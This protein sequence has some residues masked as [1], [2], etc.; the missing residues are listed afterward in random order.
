VAAIFQGKSVIPIAATMRVGLIQV[1]GPMSKILAI[2]LIVIAASPTQ[3]K[4]APLIADSELALGG[5]ALGDSEQA[6][7][8]KLGKPANVTDTGD[9]LN[10]RLDYPGLTI[11]L[12]EGRRVGE[13]LSTASGQCSPS[14][15][16]PGQRLSVATAQLGPGLVADREDGRFMEYPSAQSS[17][18]LQLAVLQG[19][20]VSVRAECQP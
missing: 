8:A 15:I 14:G 11:W 3:A 19:I 12:G 17:C 6:V 18:W 4:Q 1:L 10:I 13:I 7:L 2:L 20:I 5:I 16:C 9:F